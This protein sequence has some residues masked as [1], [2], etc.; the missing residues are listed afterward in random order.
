MREKN[1]LLNDWLFH[2]G[3]VQIARPNAKGPTYMQA[4]TEA[5]RIGPACAEYKDCP[6]DFTRKGELTGDNWERVTVPHDYTILQEPKREHN[7]SLGGFRYENAWYR[8]HF[9][10]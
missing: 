9:R 5:F 1:L 4:K 10:V 3:D 6:D 2:L 7:F 8:Y